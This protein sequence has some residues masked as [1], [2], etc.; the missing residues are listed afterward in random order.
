MNTYIVTLFLHNAGDEDRE[1]SHAEGVG[2]DDLGGEEHPRERGECGG[3]HG[4]A[5]NQLRLPEGQVPRHDDEVAHGLQ[6]R[7]EGEELL[8]EHGP[9]EHAGQGRAEAAEGEYDGLDCGVDDKRPVK[10][11]GAAVCPLPWAWFLAGSAHPRQ[12]VSS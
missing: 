10:L 4:R 7:G 12:P 11:V 2:E 3:G 6:G 8:A 9:V 5:E 1:A